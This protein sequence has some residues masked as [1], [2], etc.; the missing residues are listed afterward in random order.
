MNA[1]VQST[2]LVGNDDAL[3]AELTL[4][5][6]AKQNSACP[7]GPTVAIPLAERSQDKSGVKTPFRSFEAGFTYLAQ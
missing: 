7:E 2:L 5:G 1:K 3:D 4:T 6:L